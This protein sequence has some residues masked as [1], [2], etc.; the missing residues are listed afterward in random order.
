LEP[1]QPLAQLQQKAA[2]SAL[3]EFMLG[4]TKGSCS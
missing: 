4:A 1:K 2:L 3:R